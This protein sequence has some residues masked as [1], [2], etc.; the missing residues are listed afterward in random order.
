MFIPLDQSEF[1]KHYIFTEIE[2]LKHATPPNHIPAQKKQAGNA[3]KT[4][5]PNPRP[6]APARPAPQR[7]NKPTNNNNQGNNN[8]GPHV[9]LNDVHEY[10]L[11]QELQTM[12]DIEIGLLQEETEGMYYVSKH[13]HVSIFPLIAFY[14]S[15]FHQTDDNVIRTQIMNTKVQECVNKVNDKIKEFCT[16]LV[17]LNP[18][19]N[20]DRAMIVDICSKLPIKKKKINGM[21][22]SK[23]RSMIKDIEAEAQNS[24]VTKQFLECI[25]DDPIL[26]IQIQGSGKAHIVNFNRITSYTQEN[27]ICL[28][29]DGNNQIYITTIFDLQKRDNLLDKYVRHHASQRFLSNKRYNLDHSQMYHNIPVLP[30]S[31]MGNN[32]GIY[33]VLQF[34]DIAYGIA[35]N[36][37]VVPYYRKEL[38]RL[39]INQLQTMVHNNLYHDAGWW[40]VSIY[41]NTKMFDSN[42]PQEIMNGIKALESDLETMYLS[43]EVL[44]YYFFTVH[45]IHVGSGIFNDKAKTLDFPHSNHN[46]GVVPKH[47]KRLAFIVNRNNNHFETVAIFD[48]KFMLDVANEENLTVNIPR[49]N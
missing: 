6:A 38:K 9:L 49:I 21:Q 23:W 17:G 22:P 16:I 48:R 15:Q 34:I 37:S 31:G 46:A 25:V 3:K 43:Y 27:C 4:A 10:F 26:W 2:K 13:Q 35:Y 42:N 20:T 28:V 47:A 8:N 11:G 18:N 12:N 39:I 1:M 7:S 29:A 32:C 19:D 30:T 24:I 36:N 41:D 44:R 45:N 33:S 5:T 40:L 14:I